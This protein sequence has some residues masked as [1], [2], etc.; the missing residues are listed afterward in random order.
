MELR[1]GNPQAATDA[2]RVGLQK[3]RFRPHGLSRW[4]W[5]GGLPKSCTDPGRR[6]EPPPPQR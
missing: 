2:H 1:G 3:P 6:L 5:S 4:P